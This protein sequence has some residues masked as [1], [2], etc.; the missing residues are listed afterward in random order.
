[1]LKEMAAR[2]ELE[3]DADISVTGL[4]ESDARRKLGIL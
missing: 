4:L 3:E 2:N 1:M